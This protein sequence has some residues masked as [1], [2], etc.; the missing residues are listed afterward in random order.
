MRFNTLVESTHDINSWRPRPNRRH[1]PNVR[2]N[3]IPALVQIMAWR[4]P[5]DKPLTEPMMVSLLAHICVTRPQWVK[6]LQVAKDLSNNLTKIRMIE[7]IPNSMIISVSYALL[8]DIFAVWWKSGLY[9]SR[10]LIVAPGEK[11][12]QTTSH[13]DL[14][15][16][17]ININIYQHRSESIL[18]RVMAC[19]LTAPS[20]Y[21]N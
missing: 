5:G 14:H 2:I 16:Y 13:I 1:V 17:H 9:D 20:H 6:L 4:R 11:L 15:N 8:V 3:N 21:L 12:F 7:Q 18:V 10:I 19:S